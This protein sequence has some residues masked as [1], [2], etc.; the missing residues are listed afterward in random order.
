MASLMGRNIAT[1]SC[2]ILM[3]ASQEKNF[4]DNGGKRVVIGTGYIQA[5][6]RGVIGTGWE[7]HWKRKRKD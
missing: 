5:N 2:A 7:R 3:Q 4:G 1:G 6:R